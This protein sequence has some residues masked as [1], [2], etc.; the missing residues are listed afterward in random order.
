MSMSR[1]VLN[2]VSRMKAFTQ[3]KTNYQYER[4]SVGITNFR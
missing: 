2:L 1:M 3:K 4:T